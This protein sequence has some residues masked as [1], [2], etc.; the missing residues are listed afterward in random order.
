MPSKSFFSSRVLFLLCLFGLFLAKLPAVDTGGLHFPP[1]EGSANGKKIVLISGDEEYRT[2][3]SFPMLAKILSQKQGFNCVVLFA[4]NPEGGYIDPNFQKNIPGTDELANA[5]LLIIGTRF[6]QLPDDQLAPIAAFLNAGKP[7]IGLRTAT[8][9]FSGPAKTGD[10]KWSEFGLKILGEKWV[11]HHGRHKVEGTRG[12]VEPGQAGHEV[13]RGVGEIFVPTDVYGIANLDPKAATILLRGE[14]TESLDAGSKAVAG[15]KNSPMMPLAWLR[16]YA[17]PDGKGTGRAFCT[18]MGASVDLVDEDLRRLVVNVAF[19][20]VG[21]P[22]PGKADVAFVDPF[23]PT[24]YSAQK[25]DYYQKR[26]L[27]PAD[28]VLGR[29]P[30]TGLANSEPKKDGPKPGNKPKK[31]E[32]QE[33]A[34]VQPPHAPNAEPPAATSARPQ[35]VAPPAKGERIVLIGNGLAER[36]VQYGRIETELHL[37]YPDRE[38]FFRNMGHVGDTPGFRPHPARVSQWAF[39]GAEKFH[40]ELSIHNG[41]GFF[42]TPDQWLTHLKADTIV[43]FF[44]YNESFDGPGRVANFQAELD[45]WVLHTLGKAYNGKAAPRIVLVSP[46]A[47]ENL[48]ADRDLPS[49]EKENANLILYASAIESVAKSH[50]L[51]F[52]DLFTPTKALYAQSQQP[53]TTGGFVPNDEGYQQIAGILADGLFGKQA[54]VSK[55]YPAMVHDAVRQKDWFWNNDYNTLNGVHT[56]GQRYNPFGPQNYPDEFQKTR[57]MAALR[58]VLIHDVVSGRK[59]DLDIDDSKTHALPPVPTNYQPSA[60]NGSETYLYGEDAVKSLTVPEGYKVELFASEKE[61]PNLA[62][63]MQLSFD[64]KGRLWVAVMPTYPHYRPGDAMPNDKL[65]IY[66]DTNGDGKADKETVF[67]DNLHLPIGFEFAPEGVYVSQEPNLVLLRD[68]NG[69]DKADSKEIILGGFD[70]HDTHH[71]IGAFTADPSGAFMMCEGVFLH[72]NVETPYGPVRCV[73]GGFYRY[74]PQRGQLERTSQLSIP[75]PWGVAF[76]A[77]GQDFFLH[78]SGT[79]MNWLLPVSVKPAFGSKTPSTPDLIP[80]EHKVRPTSGLEIVSSRHFPDDVQGDIILCNA[81]GFLGIKEHRIED[82]GTGW[83]TS[84]RQDLLRSSDGNFRP[85]DLEFAPDGSLYVVDWHNVLIGHMQHNARDPLRDHVHG[86]IYRITYP[87]RPLV[88]PALVEGAPMA[89]LLDN[90]KEPELRTR[91]RSRRELR[92]RPAEEVLPALHAWVARLDKSDA[93]YEHHILEALWTT[94]GLNKTDE[95]LLR[96][97]L[98]AQD[99]HAR[100]AAVRVLRYNTHRLTDHVALL[101]KAATDDQGRVRL[102]A[103]VAA[104]WLPDVEAAKRIVALAAGRPLDE[105]SQNAVKT[106]SDRL[107]GIAEKPQAEYVTVP[108]PSYL[109][110]E[111]KKQFIAGQE[112]Y[113]REGHCMTCHRGDGNGLPP[114]FPSIVGSPWVTQNSERLIKMVLYGLMGPLEV[115]GK[116]FEG[117][118]PMTPFGG[119]LKDEE[120][121]AVLTFV[122]NHF[123]NKAD[124]IQTEQ[125]KAVRKATAGRLI[126]YTVEELLKEHP[127]K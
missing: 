3:E 61:F 31:D 50:G 35:A 60:K 51:T 115:N 82:N 10:F 62:N 23:E 79:S 113:H 89:T 38:L 1:K 37:R 77:W 123:D 57:E 32:K 83:K 85:V 43:A 98:S 110:P 20:L 30:A 105:W 59:N 104:S 121:A 95:G 66:E 11:S 92:G 13:L 47:F 15:A 125:V 28:Y 81:I 18:T 70:T 116:K 42:P 126:F 71:A 103:V 72:S 58:D 101:E 33:A 64:D 21:L 80:S 108:P 16:E 63:P 88:K 55:S 100:A 8:H 7:V 84:F 41:K 87:S 75:N 52:I 46:V 127:L 53:L 94:W 2:E 93:R 36:D 86:R 67:A 12:I 27:K 97:L 120:I 73:D 119:M 76:D 99:F 40:P 48:S 19:H 45:A 9:A 124:P 107:A 49:G 14:V 24:F 69:D 68:T 96:Q 6:R 25:S 56:H 4:I 91:Y 112:V 17:T 78:T 114:A 26:N 117:Q 74:S 54:R 90:L 34:P 109:S 22:V 5:D 102:E 122:R 65:L 111:A 39:P 118:V 44:G 29:S 106:A